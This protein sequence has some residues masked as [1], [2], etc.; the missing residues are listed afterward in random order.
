MVLYHK[1]IFLTYHSQ[2][3]LRNIFF[4]ALKYRNW[5][6]TFEKN[7]QGNKPHKSHRAK[8][9]RPL[10]FPGAGWIR[11]T[12]EKIKVYTSIEASGFANDQSWPRAVLLYF[13][14]TSLIVRLIRSSREESTSLK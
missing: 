4:G 3:W 13:P 9:F 2:F 5:L 12:K 8:E 1:I 14:L 7:N 11:N 6:I 10:G